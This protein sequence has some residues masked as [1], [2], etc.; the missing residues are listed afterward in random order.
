MKNCPFL[1][2]VIFEWSLGLDEFED[3]GVIEGDIAG[4]ELK[5]LVTRLVPV[6]GLEALDLDLGKSVDFRVR[7]LLVPARLK[8]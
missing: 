1:C 4:D 2:D 6:T 8:N 7:I 5:V 3:A